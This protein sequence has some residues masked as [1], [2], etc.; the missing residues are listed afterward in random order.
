VVV[1]DGQLKQCSFSFSDKTFSSSVKKSLSF[2]GKSSPEYIF[3]PSPNIAKFFTRQ[4]IIVVLK[5]E[6]KREKQRAEIK[7]AK[8]LKLKEEIKANKLKIE[9]I[10][11]VYG[12]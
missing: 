10:E 2:R 4:R 1:S 5:K 6:K 7:K 3:I 11:Y 12:E 9:C 8:I